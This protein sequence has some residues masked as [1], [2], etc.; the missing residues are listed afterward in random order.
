MSNL[1]R[2]VDRVKLGR[3]VQGDENSRGFSQRAAEQIGS[4]P[5]RYRSV[6]AAVRW[7]G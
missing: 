7:L 4:Y 3:H 1:I 6:S 2:W 5:V